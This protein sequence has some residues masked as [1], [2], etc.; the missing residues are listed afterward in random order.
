M[1]VFLTFIL[2]LIFFNL[3]VF[4]LGIRRGYGQCFWFFDV[5]LSGRGGMLEYRFFVD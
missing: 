4:V 2:L 1:E 3:V 5:F